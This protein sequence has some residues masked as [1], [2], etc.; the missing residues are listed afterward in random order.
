MSDDPIRRALSYDE[1]WR[2]YNR[3][4]QTYQALYDRWVADGKLGPPPPRPVR[5]HTPG[6]QVPDVER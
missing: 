4:M 5:P 1:R 2:D 3:R 6:F